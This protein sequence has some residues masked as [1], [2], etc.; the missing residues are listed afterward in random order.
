[1]VHGI[2]SS[3]GGIANHIRWLL[4]LS[5]NY[6]DMLRNL[7]FKMG[8]TL[9]NKIEFIRTNVYN[10]EGRFYYNWIICEYT[11]R[12][13][14]QPLFPMYHSHHKIDH[15]LDKLLLCL[16]DERNAWHHY[17]KFNPLT[18]G[19]TKDI[20]LKKVLTE[21]KTKIEWSSDKSFLCLSID[22]L[23]QKNLDE[24]I[25]LKLINY[26]EIEN[27][28]NDAC[29]VHEIWYNLQQKFKQEVVRDVKNNQYKWILPD[30][31]EYTDDDRRYIKQ[32]ILEEYD[33]KSV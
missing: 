31:Q 3:I 27:C 30:Q 29:V 4:L 16:V 26:F 14:L 11:H 8:T 20:F 6:N 33:D 18:N 19:E 2:V 1:M 22:G 28:Y 10:N 9:E 13:P 24:E 23:Y 15:Q 32:I 17:L 25:Y 21:S 5:K 7:P 12:Y